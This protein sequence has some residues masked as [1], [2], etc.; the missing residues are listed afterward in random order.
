MTPFSTLV[1]PSNI[2]LSG[3]QQNSQYRA[4]TVRA[5]ISGNSGCDKRC[6]L[7]GDNPSQLLLHGRLGSSSATQTSGKTKKRRFYHTIPH[8]T[9]HINALLKMQARNTIPEWNR[10][11]FFPK[12]LF[13]RRLWNMFGR[14]GINLRHFTSLLLS[15]REF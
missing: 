1:H 15:V 12:I 6:S 8:P 7:F 5:H 13:T 3:I 9:S 10:E 4:L 14:G 2:Q 11:E